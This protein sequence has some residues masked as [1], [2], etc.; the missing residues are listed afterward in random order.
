MVAVDDYIQTFLQVVAYYQYLKGGVGGMG[1]SRKELN[2]RCTQRR[3]QRTSDPGVLQSAL[4]GMSRVDE[5]CTCD[6]HHKGVEVFGFHK[7]KLDTSIGV[8]E[9]THRP[10]TIHFSWPLLPKRVTRARAT[11]LPT[12][13]EEFEISVEQI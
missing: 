3:A 10:D 2:L 4:L 8:D 11:T 5:F 6:P 13:V 1:P 7:W 9:E 12:I